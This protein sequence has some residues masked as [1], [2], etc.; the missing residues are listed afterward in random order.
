MTTSQSKYQMIMSLQNEYHKEDAI[1]MSVRGGVG[2]GGVGGGVHFI[3]VIVR[4]H[5]PL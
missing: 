5:Y 1:D 4:F 2:W 3:S